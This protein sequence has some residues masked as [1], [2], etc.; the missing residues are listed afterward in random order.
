MPGRVIDNHSPVNL[1]AGMRGCAAL[2]SLADMGSE[3]RIAVVLP[4]YNEEACISSVLDEVN[5]IRAPGMRLVPVVEPEK[6]DGL[7]REDGR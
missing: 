1:N 3:T 7:W 6:Q 2:D 4:A 5:S